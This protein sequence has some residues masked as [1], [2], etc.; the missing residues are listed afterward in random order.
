FFQ[1]EDGIRDRNVT[2]VQT[3][4]L[5]ILGCG[6]VVFLQCHDGDDAGQDHTSTAECGPQS[7]GSLWLRSAEGKGG[8]E[9]ALLLFYQLPSFLLFTCDCFR[10]STSD[11]PDLGDLVLCFFAG[12]VSSRASISLDPPM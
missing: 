8:S 2:G 9:A 6:A 10:L 5:P 3:C 4:A 1:A 11:R 12:H 7:P